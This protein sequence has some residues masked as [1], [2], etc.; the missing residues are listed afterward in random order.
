MHRMHLRLTVPLLLTTVLSACGGLSGTNEGGYI[1]LDGNITAYDEGHREGPVT[2][3]GETTQ[4]EQYS[5]EPGQVSVI[6]VWW[7]GCGPC[8][9][10]MPLLEEVSEANPEVRFLGINIRDTSAA[11]AIAF[12]R[13]MDVAYPS[14]YDPSGR[15]VASLPVRP[16]A[17][18]TTYVL[19]AEGNLA[20]MISG[21]IPSALTLEGL[22]E[23]AGGQL[24]GAGD[25]EAT[26]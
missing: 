13:E 4:G 10:E 5:L 6:N 1:T 8:R 24:G 26:P 20:S 3:S 22:I 14:I 16:I 25:D 19:D 18:P 2:V 17:P 12:E 9:E 23:D 7:S 15:V 11:N 21:V